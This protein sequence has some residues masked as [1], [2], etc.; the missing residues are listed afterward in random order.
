MSVTREPL[1]LHAAHIVTACNPYY[2]GEE[3]LYGLG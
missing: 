1:L 2:P 3:V